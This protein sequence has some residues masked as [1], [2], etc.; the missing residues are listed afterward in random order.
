MNAC[1]LILLTLIVLVTSACAGDNVQQK[2][3]ASSSPTP[4]A[5]DRAAES[6]ASTS[7]AARATGIAGSAR[8]GTAAEPV[9]PP[10]AGDAQTVPLTSA[11]DAV[12]PGTEGSARDPWE[13]FNR[14]MHGV[15]N[16]IDK[17]VTRPLAI[18]YE[19]ITPES[20]QSSV[21][22]FFKNL[23]EPTTAVNHTL[24]GRPGQGAQSLGRFVVNS[25]IG[26]G[27]LF[28]P[29]SHI[30]LSRQSSEDFGQTLAT[31][32]WRD[33]RYLVMPLLGP[34]TVRDTVSMVG[35]QPL[36]PIGYVENSGVAYTLQVM[37]LVD[38]RAR[39]LPMDEAREQAEDEYV[40]V[41]D[42][43]MQRRDRQIDQDL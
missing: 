21:T 36:S 3:D 7:E 27:G 26:I 10:S 42:A 34:R 40:L 24:Q 20:V 35:D 28:D 1:R 32:G 15:N 5:A 4:I 29:A 30:G 17:Y 19:K 13:G 25:T 11:N 6:S 23:G 14:R 2:A 22:R 43:W 39:A 33:S 31:W 37:K 18:T 41:R 38:G 8:T 9:T 16:G 12:S